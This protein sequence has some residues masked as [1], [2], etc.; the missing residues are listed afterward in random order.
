MIK[1]LIG[2]GLL[3]LAQTL[4][5]FQMYAPLKVEW[6]KDKLWITYVTAIPVTYL[7]V[8][9]AR[10]CVEYF[11]GTLWASRLLSFTLGIV[12]FTILTTIFNQE[13]INLKTGICITL[14][15]IIVL[16]QVLWK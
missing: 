11:G 12:S 1:L 15:L 5:W 4:V 9:G 3:F 14:S 10:Y 6:F 8:T 2:G 13:P 16:I 7:F